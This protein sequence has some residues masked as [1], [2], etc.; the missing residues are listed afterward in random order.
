MKSRYGIS[1]AS[2]NYPVVWAG[3]D[4]VQSMT[5]STIVFTDDA[6][7]VDGTAWT[8][9]VPSGQNIK[10]RIQANSAGGS[11]DWE[12]YFYPSSVGVPVNIVP[13]GFTNAEGI[14][15]VNMVA[16]YNGY[17]GVNCNSIDIGTMITVT[18]ILSN[19]T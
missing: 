12:V 10:T 3:G 16:P 11:M 2:S 18:V 17:I 1:G 15:T 13:L 14:C 9:V 19:L 6:D 8:S 7:A 4:S 5:A